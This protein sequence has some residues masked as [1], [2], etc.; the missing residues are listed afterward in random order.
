MP[1]ERLVSKLASLDRARVVGP[2][3]ES[4]QHHQ[5]PDLVGGTHRGI[6]RCCS[7]PTA[8]S[9]SGRRHGHAERSRPR[10]CQ[11]GKP[12]NVRSSIT[13]RSGLASMAR[14]HSCRTTCV[15]GQSSTQWPILGCASR[16]RAPHAARAGWSACRAPCRSPLLSPKP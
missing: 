3:L 8:E 10:R 9:R 1:L 15:K 7:R 13:T 4:L 14:F 2:Y 11:H 12:M 5:R 6:R 16:C